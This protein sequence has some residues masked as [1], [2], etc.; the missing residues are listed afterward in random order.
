[1]HKLRA[2]FHVPEAAT[3]PADVRSGLASITEIDGVVVDACRYGGEYPDCNYEPP[4]LGMTELQ[5]SALD[6]YCGSG[7]GTDPGS[8]WA[9]G[10]GTGDDPLPPP[11][12]ETDR[13]ECTRNAQGNCLLRSL[14]AAEWSRIGELVQR[15]A[16]GSEYCRGAK[17]IASAMYGQGLAAGRI[18]VWD[19][20]DRFINNE[21]EEDMRWGTNLSDAAGRILAYD[22]YLLF[23]KRSLF[24]HEALHAYL[25]SIN[26]PLMGDS[27]EAWVRAHE[28]ECAG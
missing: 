18:K 19:N 24:A 17:A 10:A 13:P 25:H 12:E 2:I 23:N 21:G 20:Q 26:S 9:G 8:G 7:G 4:W 14:S 28:G 16:E 3:R 6:P 5:C 1:M 11:P 22:S 15:M 27:N